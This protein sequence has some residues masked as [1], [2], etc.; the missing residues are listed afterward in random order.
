MT[1]GFSLAKVNQAFVVFP[2]RI[3]VNLVSTIFIL[4]FKSM[5]LEKLRL[6]VLQKKGNFIVINFIWLTL[7]KHRKQDLIGL[8]LVN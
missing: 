1:I 6:D 8:R 3:W 4:Y 5:N 7:G 2:S